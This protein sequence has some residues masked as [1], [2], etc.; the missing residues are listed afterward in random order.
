MQDLNGRQTFR[1]QKKVLFMPSCEVLAHAGRMLL[2]AHA[3]REK[4]SGM[5]EFAGQ[6]KYGA[7]FP[8]SGFTFHEMEGESPQD[9]PYALYQRRFSPVALRAFFKRMYDA[10][11]TGGAAPGGG[12][13]SQR[14]ILA[15]RIYR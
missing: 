1:Q 9:K 4:F 7:I 13:Y 12:N 2:V 6:G 11:F 3:L 15:G 5:I 8:E 10:R 14:A